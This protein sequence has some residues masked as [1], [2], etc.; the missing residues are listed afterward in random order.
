VGNWHVGICTRIL[1]MFFIGPLTRPSPFWM[2]RGIDMT[3]LLKSPSPAGPFEFF[4]Y[5]KLVWWFVFC[6]AFSPFQWKW[7]FYVCFGLAFALPRRVVGAED[8]VQDGLTD[9]SP[10]DGRDMGQSV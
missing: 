10:N 8:M 2:K 6:I 4:T 5:L 1:L 7:A 9:G 3:R